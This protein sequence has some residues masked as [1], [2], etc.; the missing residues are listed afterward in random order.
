MAKRPAQRPA[1]DAAKKKRK[2]GPPK[3]RRPK[4]R[5]SAVSEKA[6]L[7]LPQDDTRAA[8]RFKAGLQYIVD[9]QRHMIDWW[10]QK[11]QIR[12]DRNGAR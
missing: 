6:K 10:W 11:P 8:A 2:K 12:R 3:K 4:G 7:T 9:V 1:A 5:V